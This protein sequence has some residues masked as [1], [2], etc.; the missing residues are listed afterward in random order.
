MGEL[1]ERLNIFAAV[2][3]VVLAFLSG[4]GRLV[5]FAGAAVSHCVRPPI[6]WYLVLQQ[7]VRIGYFSLPVVGLTAFFTGAVL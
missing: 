1:V 7:M 3:R 2:G 6:Y 5:L 4:T